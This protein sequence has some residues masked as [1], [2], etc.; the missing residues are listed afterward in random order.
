MTFVLSS[1]VLGSDRSDAAHAAGVYSA[2][3][4]ASDGHLSSVFVVSPWLSSLSTVVPIVPENVGE[5]W[6][7]NLEVLGIAGAPEAADV[8]HRLAYGKPVSVLLDEADT[9]DASAIVIGKHGHHGGYGHG[10]GS[11]SRRLLHLSHRPVLVIPDDTP[12]GDGRVVVAIDLSSH[13]TGVLSW[14][15]EHIS[16]G[17]PIEVVT[18]LESTEWITAGD[19]YGFGLEFAS[20]ES[21]MHLE[22]DHRRLDDA[23]LKLQELVDASGLDNVT[24]RTSVGD[25]A[26]AI[27]EAS[28]GASALVIG[29]H[30]D[31]HDHAHR[32]L[33]SIADRVSHQAHLPVAVIPF[34]D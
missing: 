5:H 11:V 4:L 2:T 22:N 31:S 10:F 34:S 14:V 21:D 12:D 24:L 28:Q 19:P 17:T 1:I 29:A 13:S 9:V 15:K 32:M 25:P 27:I 8:T 6:D 3:H 18:A 20:L 30:G 33:G 16:D 7:S 23:T 26:V